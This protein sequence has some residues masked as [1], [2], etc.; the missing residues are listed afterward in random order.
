MLIEER[1][2][3]YVAAFWS[4]M[5]VDLHQY[6]SIVLAAVLCCW[7]ERECSALCHGDHFE[8]LTNRN[9]VY[10]VRKCTK[11]M[12]YSIV[13]GNRAA[14]FAGEATCLPSTLL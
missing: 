3:P 7:A 13:E 1:G 5:I 6:E 12:S 9:P 4:H 14:L 10:A 8:T 11:N 2:S